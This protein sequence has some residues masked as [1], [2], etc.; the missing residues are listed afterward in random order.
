[1]WACATRSNQLSHEPVAPRC[2]ATDATDATEP[3]GRSVG[4]LVFRENQLDGVFLRVKS[5]L[6]VAVAATKANRQ[7]NIH[8]NRATI[9]D[10]LNRIP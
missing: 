3:A 2:R 9:D 4:A 10:L 1:M 8:V 5:L 6:E 7:S